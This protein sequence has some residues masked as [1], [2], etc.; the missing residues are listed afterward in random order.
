[1][2][3]PGLVDVLGFGELADGRAYFVMEYLA[4]ES[5]FDRLARGRLEKDEA[6]DVFDQ[7][8]RALEAAHL[9]NVIHRDL[10]PEN[11]FLVRVANEERPIVKL[12][13]FGLAKLAVESD[14]RAEKTQSGVVI[15]TAMYLSPEQANG[16]DVDGRTDIYA[17][18][19][20]GYEV[21]LGRH[22]FLG[23]RTVAAFIAAHVHE[24]PPLPRSISTQIPPQLDLMLFAMLAKNAAH[25]PTLAQVREV[26][27]ST[28]LSAPIAPPV[29]RPA[30]A[31]VRATTEPMAPRSTSRRTVAIAVVAML[32]GVLIGAVAL[33]SRSRGDNAPVVAPN[34]SR[35]IDAAGVIVAM[36]PA[37]HDVTAKMVVAPSPPNDSSPLRGPTAT[38][39]LIDAGSDLIAVPSEAEALPVA[40]PADAEVQDSERVEPTIVTPIERVAPVA[41]AMENRPADSSAS[42]Q[43]K[44]PTTHKHR[45]APAPVAKPPVDRNQTIDPFPKKP[46]PR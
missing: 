33:G 12:L 19:C 39:P 9:H 24:T 13:D 37:D 5:L 31:E 46:A 3:H 17:L 15:G 11:T 20:I 34:V 1:M 4:G 32:G 30:V 26:I 10:K 45:P 29:P 40:A 8:A 14:R 42:P 36:P 18:G 25:R 16:P 35:S 23:A 43:R 27:A 38:R 22:P 41:P 7:M 44:P 21:F 28:R 6:L 2:H